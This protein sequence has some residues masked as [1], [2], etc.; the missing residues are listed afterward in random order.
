MLD[1]FFNS[2]SCWLQRS[3]VR[4]QVYFYFFDLLRSETEQIKLTSRFKYNILWSHGRIMRIIFFEC[5]QLLKRFLSKIIA[6][7]V[8]P[9]FATAI[10]KKINIVSVPHR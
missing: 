6:P 2:F 4:D 10:G 3:L 8:H 7:E 5:G 9:L 1:I